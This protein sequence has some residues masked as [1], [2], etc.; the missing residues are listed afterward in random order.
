MNIK[1][2]LK[3]ELH[4]SRVRAMRTSKSLGSKLLIIIVIWRENISINEMPMTQIWKK[5]LIELKGKKISNQNEKYKLNL[6]KI[7]GINFFNVYN[8]MFHSYCVF[9]EN[10]NKTLIWYV[11][12]FFLTQKYLNNCLILITYIYITN[13]WDNLLTL[14]W[15]RNTF[16]YTRISISLNFINEARIFYY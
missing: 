16:D 12:H 8:K 9:Q 13:I 3:V 6:W 14:K 2:T 11:R 7:L 5:K 1:M 10:N 4:I 15:N